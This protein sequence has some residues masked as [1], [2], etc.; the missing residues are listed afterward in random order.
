MLFGAKLG[1]EFL[2][3]LVGKLC[4]VVRYD[5]LG[6]AEP[7]KYVLFV[8]AKHVEGGDGGQGFCFHP[9]GKVV[10]GHD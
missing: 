2:K 5:R 3:F 10:Y 9:L 7:C 4:P 1:Y 8:E 6:D